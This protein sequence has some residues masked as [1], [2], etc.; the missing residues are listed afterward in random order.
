MKFATT[1]VVVVL[2]TTLTTANEDQKSTD[3]TKLEES[4]FAVTGSTFN[5][6]EVGDRQVRQRRGTVIT[7]NSGQY[8]VKVVKQPGKS[9]KIIHLYPVKKNEKKNQLQPKAE[10]VPRPEALV[11]NGANKENK[12][13]VE[14]MM[15]LSKYEEE[16][17]EGD[18]HQYEEEHK[19]KIKIKHHHHH[20]HH[21]HVK[22]VVKK[23]PYPV[24]KIVPKPYP[25]EK[26][27][28]KIIHM[29]VEKIVHKPFPVPYPVEKIIEKVVHVP[30]PYPVKEYVEKKVPYP[31]EKIVE[32]VVEKVVNKYVHIPKPYPVIKHVHVPV[33][34]KVPVPVEKKVYVPHTVEVEKKVPYPVKVYVPQPYPVEKK[35]PIKDHKH[36]HHHHPHHQYSS[37]DDHHGYLEH[38]F[39]EETADNDD[40]HSL[41]SIQRHSISE[42]PDDHYHEQMK[43]FQREQKQL[44]MQN[45]NTQQQQ[46]K[47]NEKF[48]IYKKFQQKQQYDQQIQ[49]QQVFMD[50][51]LKQME[52][53]EQHL[54][55]KQKQLEKHQSIHGHFGQKMFSDY[56]KPFYPTE[57]Q[58]QSI[59]TLQ[60]H[61]L[62]D[63]RFRPSKK[64]IPEFK[65]I[66]NVKTI[67]LEQQP[68][69]S[70]QQLYPVS[71]DQMDGASSNVEPVAIEP[72]S[73]PT[74][75]QSFRINVAESEQLPKAE[76]FTMDSPFNFQPQPD[77]NMFQVYQIQTV[78]SFPPSTKPLS[79]NV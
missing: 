18:S 29:P 26:I 55:D 79:V 45:Q 39:H 74:D 48:K 77:F 16:P 57:H 20:H 68:L 43:H 76:A 61:M 40:Q 62:Q 9:G 41:T 72:A 59:L 3:V 50:Q 46:E 49:A 60:T 78:P 22:T 47:L 71:M 66:A 56:A 6:Q 36:H 10:N 11:D 52:Q 8:R 21:N 53:M 65:P 27:V 73:D 75:K 4:K 70:T 37:M 30:K 23:E 5:H 67:P 17:L 14:K 13:Q 15:D 44:D 2:L 19:E 7:N 42:T 69:Q 25:V 54:Q 33:E 35:T 64:I 63:E 51:Q 31:V 12:E 1:L 24:E 32:K 58:H 28:E 34:V 38:K